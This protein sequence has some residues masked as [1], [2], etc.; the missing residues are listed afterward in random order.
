MKL[1]QKIKRIEKS[2]HEPEIEL[3]NLNN[4]KKKNE[5]CDNNCDTKSRNRINW[6]PL[7]N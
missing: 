1:T 7:A 4:N 5:I 2:F 3:Y 6:L